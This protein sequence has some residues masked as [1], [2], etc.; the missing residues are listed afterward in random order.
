MPQPDPRLNLTGQ[1]Y[2]AHLLARTETSGRNP[3]QMVRLCRI[4]MSKC[5][6]AA[7]LRDDRLVRGSLGFEQRS[8]IERSQ[9]LDA[10][11]GT[12][13]LGA[14]VQGMG[15]VATAAL[16]QQFSSD[17]A[18]LGFYQQEVAPQFDA[19]PVDLVARFA[20]LERREDRVCKVA[21]SNPQQFRQ[22]VDAAGQSFQLDHLR[23]SFEMS[24]AAFLER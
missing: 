3:K 6:G 8:S 5:S 19:I 2:R 13:G 17:A 15:E 7:S 10:Q 11:R 14:P 20:A 16:L 22:P 23:I 24:K 1:G 9:R 21:P 12:S 4:S 18:A